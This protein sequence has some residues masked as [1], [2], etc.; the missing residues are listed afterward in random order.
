MGQALHMFV[1]QSQNSPVRR[2][3]VLVAFLLTETMYLLKRTGA[4]GY[5]GSWSRGYRLQLW[6]STAVRFLL[7]VRGQG[8][9]SQG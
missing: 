5:F 2:V 3:L 4:G 8:A 1:V 9:E 7:G 6:K